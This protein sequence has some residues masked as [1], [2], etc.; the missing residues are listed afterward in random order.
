MVINL[1]FSI[2]TATSTSKKTVALIKL[3]SIYF[4]HFFNIAKFTPKTTEGSTI[5]QTS[6]FTMN[7]CQNSVLPS[8]LRI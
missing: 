2:I 1:L 6:N 7:Q 8:I 5:Q 4:I 3:T